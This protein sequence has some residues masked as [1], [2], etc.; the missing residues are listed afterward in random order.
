MIRIGL[1]CLIFSDRIQ[2]SISTHKAD[3]DRTDPCISRSDIY[4]SPHH[5]S[6]PR[7]RISRAVTGLMPNRSARRLKIGAFFISYPLFHLHSCLFYRILP[8]AS[9]IPRKEV[10]APAQGA[11]LLNPAHAASVCP[12]LAS[13]SV[14]YAPALF[15]RLPPQ[16]SVP[17]QNPH[18][19]PAKTVPREK[20]SISDSCSSTNLIASALWT[21]SF[22]C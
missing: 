10:P 19:I 16:S 3:A 7:L 8:V 22:L 18:H 12:S 5:R 14:P 4:Q 15:C 6:P 21:F 17:R 9:R 2:I 20:R 11:V 13:T 1:P